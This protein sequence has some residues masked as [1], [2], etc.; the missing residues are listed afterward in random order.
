MAESTAYLTFLHLYI[1][2]CNLWRFEKEAHREDVECYSVEV[3]SN[4]VY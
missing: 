4:E 1:R 3:M 2:Y